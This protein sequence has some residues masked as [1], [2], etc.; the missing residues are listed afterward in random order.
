MIAQLHPLFDRVRRLLGF[1]DWLPP[2]IA[3]GVTGWVFIESGWGK[4]QHL[5]KV[6]AFFTSLKIPSPEIQARLVSSLELGCGLL[7]FL[8]LFTRVASAPLIGI[9]C[10]ALATAKADDIK[11][12]S[13][14][15]SLSEFL[16]IIFFI[17][18]GVNGPGAVSLDRIIFGKAG[19][20]A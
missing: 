11:V 8:G 1:L 6:I 12:F 2:L 14:L 20:K 5:D 17:W 18:L 4:F 7:V 15:F 16:Y 10:V 13:D 19:K 9:M 3:R